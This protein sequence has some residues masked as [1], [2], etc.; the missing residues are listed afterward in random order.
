MLWGK[1]ESTCIFVK[2]KFEK[3]YNIHEAMWGVDSIRLYRHVRV[4]RYQSFWEVMPLGQKFLLNSN[5]L[6]I[7]SKHSLII[8]TPKA[9][10]KSWIRHSDFSEYIKQP[11][12]LTQSNGLEQNLTHLFSLTLKWR[13]YS[14]QSADLKKLEWGFSSW[15]F[16]T[17]KFDAFSR[18]S[19]EK[20]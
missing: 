4:H 20:I 19:L 16:W 2:K 11:Y 10:S 18:L 12:R 13:Y 3:A 9:Y 6:E 7:D 8:C 15:G 17:N 14:H 5:I 1:D